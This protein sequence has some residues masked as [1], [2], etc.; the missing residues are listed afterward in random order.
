MAYQPHWIHDGKKGWEEMMRLEQWLVHS[1]VQHEGMNWGDG[2]TL[3]G[4]DGGTSWEIGGGWPD[5]TED[6]D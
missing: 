5:E 6:K 4:W 3:Q 1:I 2:M